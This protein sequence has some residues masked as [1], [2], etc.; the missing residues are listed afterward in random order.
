[1]GV[2]A[3][4]VFIAVFAVSAPLLILSTGAHKVSQKEKVVAA[5]DSA[6]GQSPLPKKHDPLK[7]RKSELVSAIPWLNKHLEKLYIIPRLRALLLQ[8]N[9]K[10]T[11]GAVILM[12]AAAFAIPAY[13]L[14]AYAHFG[15]RYASAA[16]ILGGAPVGYILM[17]RR[18]RFGKFEEGLPEALDLMVNGLRAGH[19]L[20]A[21]I[22]LVTRECPDPIGAEFRIAYD[23]QNFGLDL[24]SSLDNLVNRVPIPDMKIAVTAI[25]IQRESGG[26]LAEVLEK[27]SHMIR[28]RFKLKR[29]IR[30]LT[31]S[32]RLTGWILTLMPIVLGIGLY[33]LNPAGMSV[34]WTTEM[35]RHMLIYAA[36]SIIV[37]SVAIQ[38][39][40][41]MKV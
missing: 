25:I 7:F 4:L 20:S 19:S 40:V 13:L 30:V 14:S 17:K 5:L 11:P 12:C 2:V 32:G 8:A 24:R 31:A 33:I 35:G 3:A 29:Q 10:W 36:C 16:F 34:L 6:I 28:Q 21:A 15:G 26:N 1:M 18:Q 41:R 39:I 27:T 9:V 37:G 23:E 38:K 22:G